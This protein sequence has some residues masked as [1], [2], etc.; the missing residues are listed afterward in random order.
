MN[1]HFLRLGAACLIALTVIAA[2]GCSRPNKADLGNAICADYT[3]QLKA[4][5]QIDDP[6][7]RRV[8]MLLL[9]RSEAA[10]LSRLGDSRVT[11][12]AR[13][14]KAIAKWVQTRVS[15]AP[16][17]ITLPDGWED[18]YHKTWQEIGLQECATRGSEYPGTGVG[19]GTTEEGEA[20]PEG[21]APIPGYDR[22]G[23]EGLPI[24]TDGS[25]TLFDV[26]G[27]ADPAQPA[28]P[29]QTTP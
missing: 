28:D 6:N 12:T 3:R 15:G 29:A 13:V 22:D 5:S 25:G 7:L 14:E 24:R 2:S 1:R 18:A 26:A 19:D 8:R 27:A 4:A 16:S 11:Q 17:D 23:E 10:A 20:P 9:H 21:A